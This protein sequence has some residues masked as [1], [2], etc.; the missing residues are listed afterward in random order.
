MTDN[1]NANHFGEPKK[2]NTI[3]KH[4]LLSQT[5]Q[6]SLSIANNKCVAYKQN[7]NKTDNIYTYIDLFAGAGTFE[8]NSKGSP[9]IAYDILSEHNN[10][11]YNKF[12][13]LQM[14]CTEKHDE[15][16]QKLESTISTY[17][18]NNDIDCYIG[19]GSWESY[20]KNIE[21][22]LENSGWGFIFADPFS[23]ELDIVALIETLKSYSNLKDILVFFNFNT[24]ARQDGRRCLQDIDRICRTI[25]I[26]EKELLDDDSNF[27]VK[28]ENKLIEHFKDLKK[29][30]IG[31]GFPTTVNGDLI[32]S[33]YFYLIFSTNTPV[34]VDTFLNAYEEMLDKYTNYSGMQQLALFGNPDKNYI[35]D[36]LKENFAEG[37]SLFELYLFITSKFLSWKELTKTQKKV[38]TIKNIVEIL[39]E[40]ESDNSIRII[41]EEKFLYKKT[42]KNGKTGNLKYAEAGNSA[43]NMKNIKIV[44]NR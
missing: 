1:R 30:V 37:C 32:N 22:L 25:G 5:L 14:A 24:L 3:I 21:L 35:Y 7:S 39:N 29:F 38:P 31:V 15:S 13:K 2:L 6:T 8:D 41:A 19:Q 12:K 11:L 34:L 43:E 26:D 40:F 27:S 42:S 44:L 16:F 10:S 36:V 20:K 33:D 4:H 9:I 28:F 18:T 17:T 23:T